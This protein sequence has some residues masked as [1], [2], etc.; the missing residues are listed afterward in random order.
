PAPVRPALAVR[1]EQAA[2]VVRTLPDLRAQPAAEAAPRRPLV[3]ARRRA[4]VNR[5]VRSPLDR[6]ISR[7]ELQI[8]SIDLA[9]SSRTSPAERARTSGVGCSDPLG[10]RR[11]KGRAA[12]VGCSP[13]PCP[14][15]SG[16]PRRLEVVRRRGPIPSH[17]L[18]LA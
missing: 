14:P 15:C 4:P 12:M 5:A 17:E 13:L 3:W 18:I 11:T 9:G 6:G 1:G 8:A 16:S 2:P 10:D 7:S